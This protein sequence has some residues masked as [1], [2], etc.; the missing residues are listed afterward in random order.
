MS[1]VAQRKIM[2]PNC[3]KSERYFVLYTMAPANDEAGFDRIMERMRESFK[4]H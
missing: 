3:D 2:L 1:S 4:C